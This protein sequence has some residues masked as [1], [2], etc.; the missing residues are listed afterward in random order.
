MGLFAA[1][2]LLE[3]REGRCTHP[4]G[5]MESR[6][7]GCE[8]SRA[9]AR[10]PLPSTFLIKDIQKCGKDCLHHWQGLGAHMLKTS[11]L[12]FALKGY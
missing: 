7:Y 8:R 10:L 3:N 2:V 5:L 11:P 6:Y 9:G 4:P 12:L 1:S